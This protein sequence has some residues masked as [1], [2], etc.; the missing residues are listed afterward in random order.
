MGPYLTPQEVAAVLR[1]SVKSLYRWARDPKA[2]LPVV[3][4]GGSLRF[5]RPSLERWLQAEEQRGLRMRKQV[6]SVVKSGPSAAPEAR[7]ADP[8]AEGGR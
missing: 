2:R 1:I 7:C 5:S 6:L 4:I 8:C 3:R